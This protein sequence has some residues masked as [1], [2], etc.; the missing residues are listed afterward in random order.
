MIDRI[1]NFSDIRH[2]PKMCT[3]FVPPSLKWTYPSYMDESHC[4]GGDALLNSQEW[5]NTGN[6]VCLY[7]LEHK[8]RSPFD[9]NDFVF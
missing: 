1:S 6:R 7:T 4:I 3:L 8:V 2:S 9:L 5:F